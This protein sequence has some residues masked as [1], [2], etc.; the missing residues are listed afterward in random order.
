MSRFC[1]GEVGVI[2]GLQSVD[3][4]QLAT[5]GQRTTE[6]AAGLTGMR[7]KVLTRLGIEEFVKEQ[8]VRCFDLL[9]KL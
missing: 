8:K 7:G 5:A 6:S 4:G 2:S 3:A 9:V 1:A